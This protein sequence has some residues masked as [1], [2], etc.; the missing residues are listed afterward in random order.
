MTSLGRGREVNIMDGDFAAAVAQMRSSEE[1]GGRGGSEVLRR[2]E[3]A[4]DARAAAVGVPSCSSDGNHLPDR[5][6]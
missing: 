2:E 1:K 4:A 5:Q 6:T 3:S